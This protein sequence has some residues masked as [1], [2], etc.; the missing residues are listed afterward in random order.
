[1]AVEAQLVN[2][3]GVAVDGSGNLYFANYFN[4]HI[5]RVDATGTISPDYA[6]DL[7]PSEMWAQKKGRSSLI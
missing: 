1:M 4:E 5:R 7:N 2:P 6:G 3:K